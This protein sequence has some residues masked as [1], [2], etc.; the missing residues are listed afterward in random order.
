MIVLDGT[1]VG[2][3]FYPYAKTNKE[4]TDAV[5]PDVVSATVNS[6]VITSENDHVIFR[7]VGKIVIV[8]GYFYVS[9]ITRNTLLY[10]INESILADSNYFFT[11]FSNAPSSGWLKLG[12]DGLLRV[13][14]IEGLV[15]GYYG[16]T[17][18]FVLK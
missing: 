14:S 4:L 1:D 15:A 13:E 7:K 11:V 8:E 5:T 18:S 12:S 6:E 16:I 9:A 2:D 10:T 17:G 3:T